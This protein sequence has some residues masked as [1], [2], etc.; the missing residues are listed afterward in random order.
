MSRPIGV[1]KRFQCML[2]WQRIDLTLATADSK[3]EGHMWGAASVARIKTLL[4]DH[5]GRRAAMTSTK[6]SLF[7]REEPCSRRQTRLPA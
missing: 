3:T 4:A 6:S 5:P 1:R 7:A 2:C